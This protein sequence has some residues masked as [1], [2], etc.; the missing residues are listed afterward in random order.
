MPAL[1]ARLGCEQASDDIIQEG[2]YE[3]GASRRVASHHIY[4][5]G[6]ESIISEG[7]VGISLVVAGHPSD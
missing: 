6:R 2:T 1:A 4:G 5:I 7:L 3:P